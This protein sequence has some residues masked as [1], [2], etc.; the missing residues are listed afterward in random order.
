ME[1]YLIISNPSCS[2]NL[3]T[4]G[5][6][7][8]NGKQ[9]SL[10]G[11]GAVLFDEENKVIGEFKK[12]LGYGKTNNIAEYEALILGLKEAL[13]MNIKNI[14]VYVDSKLL[15]EQVRGNYKVKN[16]GLKP[17][18]EEVKNLKSRFDKFRITHVLRH[19]NSHADKL[20][21]EAISER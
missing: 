21:N 13:N 7:K 20:A 14:N 1:K 17:L 16:V 10:S 6:C 9:K 19:L 18:F 4:D 11:A 8:G 3:Y 5:A 12:F 2:S 15:T